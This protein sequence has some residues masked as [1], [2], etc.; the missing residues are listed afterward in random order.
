[1]AIQLNLNTF[2]LIVGDVLCHRLVSVFRSA[3]AG[4]DHRGF[5]NS[6]RTQRSL[7]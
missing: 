1:M 3:D 7:R 2:K 4:I 6:N 5:V